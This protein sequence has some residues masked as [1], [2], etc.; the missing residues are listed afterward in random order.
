MSNLV[1]KG[2]SESN[3]Q[4]SENPAFKPHEESDEI[5]QDIRAKTPELIEHSCESSLCST[6]ELDDDDDVFNQAYD[7]F[8]CN[9]F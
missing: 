9:S 8:V 2:V 1:D 7:Q 6:L 5:L 3:F 4:K